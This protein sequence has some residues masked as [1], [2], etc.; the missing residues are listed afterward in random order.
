MRLNLF[1]VVLFWKDLFISYWVLIIWGISI[2]LINNINKYREVKFD[3]PK[4]YLCLFLLP[5]LLFSHTSCLDRDRIRTGGFVFSVT[6]KD[7][8]SI[9]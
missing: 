2:I 8:L 3:K 6:S 9:S 7:A 5:L 1:Y 4:P